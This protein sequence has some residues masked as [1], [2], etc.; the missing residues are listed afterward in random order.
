M[1][2]NGK[3]IYYH[4]SATYKNI[5]YFRNEKGDSEIRASTFH[6]ICNI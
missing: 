5:L 1:M 2:Y 6:F 4:I 3:V